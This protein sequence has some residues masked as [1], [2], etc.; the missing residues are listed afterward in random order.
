MGRAV[1]KNSRPLRFEFGLREMGFRS[2]FETRSMAW[3]AKTGAKAP[4]CLDFLRGPEGPLFHG[5]AGSVSCVRDCS[6]VMRE[7]ELSRDCSS[8]MRA[9]ELSGDCSSVMHSV[10]CLASVLR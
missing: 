7:F 10:F 6:A 3:K 1:D 4:D 9:C 8:M 5:D 2:R